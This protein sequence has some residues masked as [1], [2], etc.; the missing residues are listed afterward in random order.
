MSFFVCSCESIVSPSSSVS[1]CERWRTLWKEL[2]FCATRFVF[3][4]GNTL[5]FVWG[6]LCILCVAYFCVWA[7]FYVNDSFVQHFVQNI[8]CLCRIFPVVLVWTCQLIVS[9]VMHVWECLEMW[10][11]IWKPWGQ[12]FQCHLKWL[13]S[14]WMHKAVIVKFDVSC[15]IKNMYFHEGKSTAH[16]P[17]IGA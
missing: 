1:W 15:Q 8:L 9:S 14:F 11:I 7:T 3:C 4:V 2:I 10:G 13:Q 12:K 5:Y 6:I 17:I 16:P